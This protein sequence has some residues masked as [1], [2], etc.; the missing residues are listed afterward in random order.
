MFQASLET[1]SGEASRK[2]LM[3]PPLEKCP[4]SSPLISYA[5]ADTDLSQFFKTLINRLS[6]QFTSLVLHVTLGKLFGAPY[7][8]LSHFRRFIAGVIRLLVM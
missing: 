6:E 2:P 8:I 7:I 3:L 5:A 1:C 4:A